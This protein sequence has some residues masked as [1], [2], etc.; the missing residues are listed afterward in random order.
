MY[1]HPWTEASNCRSACVRKLRKARVW[2]RA[3]QSRPIPPADT[4]ARLY[5]TG[6]QD[7]RANGLRVDFEQQ[8]KQCAFLEEH[9][10]PGASRVCVKLK[11]NGPLPEES[12]VFLLAFCTRNTHRK[13]DPNVY[14]GFFFASLYSEAEKKQ[15]AGVNSPPNESC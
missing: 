2:W 8:V 6:S 5:R 1:K 14:V 15:S 10:Q 3:L 7:R 9:W 11:K 4:S 13:R 12:D